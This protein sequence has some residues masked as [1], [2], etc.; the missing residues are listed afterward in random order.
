MRSNIGHIESL[1]AFSG[2][3]GY[4]P[5]CDEIESESR[6]M[7]SIAGYSWL[8]ESYELPVINLWQE[9]W[10]DSA[11]KGRK[12]KD[13]GTHKVEYFEASYKPDDTL[14]AHLQFA[15][16]Y[17][18]VNLQLLSLLFERTGQ[19]ELA[20]WITQSPGS[21]YARRACFLYEWL[22][23][24]E[25]PIESPVSSKARYI[26]ALDT[27]MQFGLT[28]GERTARFR[29]ANNLP[30]TPQ[31]CPL[32]RRTEYLQEIQHKDLKKQT[33]LTLA[34]YDEDLVLRA[35]AFL[36]LK[37]TQSSFEVE[38]EKP[39]PERAQRFADLLRQADTGTPLNEERLADLQNAIVD[40]RFHEFGWRSEQNWLGDDLGYR[41]RVDFV[42]PRP[43]D[44]PGLMQGLLDTA[45]MARTAIH[46]D[47]NDQTKE[48]SLAPVIIAATIAFGFVFI[49]PYMD[50]NGRI[51][52]YL[53]HEVLA[54]AG[55]TPRGIVLPVSA[56]I[57][58]NLDRYVAVL[59]NFS[60]PARERTAY[61]PAVPEKPATGNDAVYFSFFDATE[62]AEFLCWALIQTIEKDF[63]EEIDFLVGFDRAQRSLNSLLDWP[64]HDLSL[65]IRV[66]HQ[67]A[68]HLSKTK[69]ASHFDWMTDREIELAEASVREAFNIV[70]AGTT[71]L[72][73]D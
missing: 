42:P 60:K 12:T 59:E 56:V 10:I 68:G 31:F 48:S 63:Q 11:A 19:Q 69:T 43:E 13:L 23:N 28:T 52:R 14:A 2:N 21:A 39:S 44:V 70:D 66:V 3:C 7:R 35:A 47:K 18:G 22:T 64:R 72:Q 55:F 53:I 9:C 62:Q 51:H 32:V 46:S 15:L 30:G 40:P 49:H 57:L 73:D 67:N 58:A 5:E 29:I 1:R 20:D 50:G 33:R 45:T 26:D 6:Q 65:F 41:Q 24:T 34:R 16:R 54:N 38:R 4:F 36:Y 71:Q 37:E 61:L 27:D 17:E 8:K 25:V